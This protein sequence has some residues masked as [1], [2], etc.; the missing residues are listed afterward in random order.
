[1]LGINDSVRSHIK[2]KAIES[3]GLQ[4]E[5]LGFPVCDIK[6]K[7]TTP[8]TT[9]P[10]YLDNK[11]SYTLQQRVPVLPKPIRYRD[12]KGK[13]TIDEGWYFIFLISVVIKKDD[14]II[15]D[16]TNFLVESIDDD[17]NSGLTR[18]E[19]RMP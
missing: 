17:P 7:I 5:A 4:R 2:A 19:G 10:S 18:I 9:L 14:I 15:Y 6:T 12:I 13:L 11:E 16:G 8:G 3:W 1:M